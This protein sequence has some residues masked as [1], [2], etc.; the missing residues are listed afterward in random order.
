MAH[1]QFVVRDYCIYMTNVLCMIGNLG[2]ASA[3]R[4][5]PELYQYT[6]QLHKLSYR[7]TV[8][9]QDGKD[10]LF[11]SSIKEQRLRV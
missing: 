6:A 11:V 2:A 3:P 5:A 8:R 1:S 10:G 7:D 4:T 9:A